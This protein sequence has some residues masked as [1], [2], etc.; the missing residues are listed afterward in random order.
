MTS[1]SMRSPSLTSR[2]IPTATPSVSAGSANA[3]VRPASRSS[4]AREGAGRRRIV[5]SRRFSRRSCQ[6]YSAESD[7]AI[8]KPA[9]AMR[10]SPTCRTR[11]RFE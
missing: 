3:T 1:A 9:N 11:K 4:V 5:A 8:V 10:T 2:A 6:M 7:A